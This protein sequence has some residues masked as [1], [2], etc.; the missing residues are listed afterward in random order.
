MKAKACCTLFCFV[1]YFTF[2]ELDLL[3]KSTTSFAVLFWL[4]DGRDAFLSS[5]VSRTLALLAGG[6]FGDM[7]LLILLWRFLFLVATVEWGLLFG[8]C[9]FKLL[10]GLL[11]TNDEPVPAGLVNMSFLESTSSAGDIKVLLIFDEGIMF[12]PTM[13][14]QL[15]YWCCFGPRIRQ[16]LSDAFVSPIRGRYTGLVAWLGLGCGFTLLELKSLFFQ[17]LFEINLALCPIPVR[18]FWI[19]MSDSISL[20]SSLPISLLEVPFWA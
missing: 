16:P 18:V 11:S 8:T 10:I 14:S 4:L 5:V 20:T 19:K 12:P 1:L 2:N 9:T 6:W 17:L 15:S 13:R 3:P 7:P